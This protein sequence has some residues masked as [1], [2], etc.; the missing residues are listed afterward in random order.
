MIYTHHSQ[1][2]RLSANSTKA[3]EPGS[4]FL[5]A[6]CWRILPAESTGI[7]GT[8]YGID[9]DGG[10][11]CLSCCHVWDVASMRDRS[12]PFGAYLSS[13][14]RTVCN[15]P[16]GVLGHV[17]QRSVSRTGW[18]GSRLTHVRVRDV[19]GAMWHGKGAGKGVCITLRPM[20]G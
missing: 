14:G 6:T 11:H 10:M 20:K 13:D 8:Q 19:H 1:F 16:G 17:V 2:V 7:C 15:W 12:S 9:R 5:C 18:H 3:A 4:K